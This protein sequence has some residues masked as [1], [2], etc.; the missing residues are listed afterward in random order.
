MSRRFD[1]D[2]AVRRSDKVVFGT[3]GVAAYFTAKGQAD[4]REATVDTIYHN[5]LRIQDDYGNF[6]GTYGGHADGLTIDSHFLEFQ[7]HEVNDKQSG[8]IIETLD[9]AMNITARYRLEQIAA[10][11]QFSVTYS[12]IKL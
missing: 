2:A 1:F 7:R 6:V 3:I 10:L 12:V 8:A 9:S 11:D 5:D 4:R